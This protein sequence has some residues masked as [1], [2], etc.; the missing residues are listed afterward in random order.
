[1][2]EKFLPAFEGLADGLKD[3]GVRL[4]MFFALCT[5]IA[6]FVLHLETMEWVAVI[7][8]IAMVLSTEMLNTCIEDLCNLY[9][10]GTDERI[11]KIKDMAA[12]AVLI[13]GLG[14]LITALVIL[15]RHI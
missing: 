12:S 2:K 14:S 6:G 11:R 3:P 4:Q 10:T 13:T 8:C 7:I 5:L 1:M 15:F 9:S